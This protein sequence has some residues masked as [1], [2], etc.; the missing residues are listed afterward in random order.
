MPPV[1]S[2]DIPL[3]SRSR[4]LWI[5]KSYEI[6]KWDPWTVPAATRKEI[7]NVQTCLVITFY[8][9]T[10]MVYIYLRDSLCFLIHEV[11]FI[12]KASKNYKIFASL[13][14]VKWLLGMS[15]KRFKG[16]LL[17]TDVKEQTTLRVLFSLWEWPHTKSHW[18]LQEIQ[19]P[20][21]PSGR[22]LSQA[23]YNLKYVFWLMFIR[24][25]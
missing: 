23:T 6:Y 8:L 10:W 12:F 24:D 17:T 7:K 15:L 11:Y 25:P 19:A 22:S 18:R 3:E 13:L 21:K 16:I 4:K 20:C 1:N 14:I 2:K 9:R 5:S